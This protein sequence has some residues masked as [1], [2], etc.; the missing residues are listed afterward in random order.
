MSNCAGAFIE[1]T[2]LSISYNIMGIATISYTMV[3]QEPSFCYD[4]TL[5]LGGVTF[6]GYVTDMSLDQIPGTTGWYETHVSL[7][8]TTD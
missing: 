3:H 7:T 8:T 6:T 5:T 4:T 1:C 2:S